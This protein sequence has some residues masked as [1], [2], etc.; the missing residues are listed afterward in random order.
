VVIDRIGTVTDVPGQ[1]ARTA[2]EYRAIHA[3]RVATRRR[4]IRG[5]AGLHV[6]ETNVPVEAYV[7]MGIWRMRC[8]CGEAPSTHPT[9]RLACCAGCGAIYVNVIFPSDEER[10]AIEAVL[11]KR[12]RVRD[13]N[14]LRDWSVEDLIAQNIAHGDPA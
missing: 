8:V 1:G 13:R 9:M 6:Y 14:W 10:A 3:A 5:L 11:V 2:D 7:T 4:K 12:R